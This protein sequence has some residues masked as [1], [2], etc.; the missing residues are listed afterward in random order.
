MEFVTTAIDVY[1]SLDLYIMNVQKIV[2]PSEKKEGFRK[3]ML[4]RS[5]T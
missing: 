4:H 5:G 1:V 3:D 2:Y